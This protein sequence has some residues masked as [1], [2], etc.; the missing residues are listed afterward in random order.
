M[1]HQIAAATRNLAWSANK[2]AC[3]Q[4][5]SPTW[6]LKSLYCCPPPPSF[7]SAVSLPQSCL[8]L[9]SFSFSLQP[10]MQDAPSYLLLK[11]QASASTLRPSFSSVSLVW[12][13]RKRKRKRWGTFSHSLVES[14]HVHLI[15]FVPQKGAA[16]EKKK[17]TRRKKDKNAPKGACNA[18]TLF[19]K[20]KSKEVNSKCCD[21]FLSSTSSPIRFQQR[22]EPSSLRLS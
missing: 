6:P 5:H 15:I 9:P 17:G 21:P 10:S 2:N 4:T 18:Y 22:T 7:S 1:S 16:V 11:S 8:P 3:T 13:L 20:S 12:Q 14:L 19:M